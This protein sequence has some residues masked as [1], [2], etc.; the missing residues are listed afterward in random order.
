[1]TRIPMTTL[2]ERFEKKVDRSG[3]HH[4]WFGSKKTDGTGKLKVDGKTVT[5]ARVAWEL[6]HGPLPRGVDVGACETVKGCVRVEH[7]S[8]NGTPAAPN[9]KARGSAPHGSGSKS[10]VRPGV[11]KFT[12]TAGRYQDG[13]VRRAYS[14]VRARNEREATKL[15]AAFV[16]EVSSNQLAS[17]KGDRDLTLDAAVEQFLTEHLLGEKGRD[18]RTAHDYR[19]LHAKW[20]SPHIGARRLHDIDEAAMDRLFGRMR[21]A[22]LSRSRLNQAKSLYA[23]LFRWAKRRRLIARNPMAEFEL[24]T[25]KH[26]S[27]ERVPPEVEQ[28][29][30]LL[31]TAVEVVPDVA[32]VLALGAVT[33]MRRGE[34]V[35]LRRSRVDR[36]ELSSS[37]R[38]RWPCWI[39]TA[40]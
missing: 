18:E 16:A 2:A 26:V 22:G 11:W 10:E 30:L 15:L 34:L 24:P 36:D 38:N 40:K 17:S 23:P 27:R 39:D 21:R 12:V 5:A 1:M 4:L 7:L 28:L 37:T 35:G 6:V 3:E 33:G 9:T 29:C 8:I 14:T 32:P 19:Q 20:F 13:S 25:S 31:E